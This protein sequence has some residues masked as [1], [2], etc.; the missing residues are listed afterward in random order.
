MAI[1]HRCGDNASGVYVKIYSMKI[2]RYILLAA[3]LTLGCALRVGAADFANEDLHYVITY[4]W[5]LIHKEAGTATLSL[6]SSGNDYRLSLTARTKPWADRVF[7]VRDTLTSIVGRADLHP[8]RYVKAAHEGG[9][10]SLDEINFTYSG[11]NVK[12]CA[13]RLRVDKKGTATKGET[14][15]TATGPTFDMLSVF[16]FLR[17]LDYAS[18]GN[19]A[20]ATA[21]I[22][23]G[24]KSEK[25]TIRSLGKERIEMRDKSHAEAWHIKFRFTSGGGRKSSDDIDAW[26]STD[27]RHIP[28]RLYGNLPIGQV[29][30]YLVK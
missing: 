1:L 15:L 3:I 17:T 9:K 11:K 6:R 30:V 24:S 5:G 8:R 22:F 4:K 10:Y 16:Y 25:L 12:G 26:I 19:G 21:N 2:F 28:L 7:Q 27:Q 18:L 13:K 14:E 20:T 29:R 23:S